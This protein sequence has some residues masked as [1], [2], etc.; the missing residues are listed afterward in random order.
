MTRCDPGEPGRLISTPSAAGNRAAEPDWLAAPRGAA[1]ARFAE[2]GFP[3]RRSEGLALHR[4]APAD[5][6]DA[7][8]AARRMPGAAARR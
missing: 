3:T 8:G 1:L 2:L 7:S 6:A 4:S 5:S